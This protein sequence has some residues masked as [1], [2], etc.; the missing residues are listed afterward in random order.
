MS[1][2]AKER[3]LLTSLLPKDFVF[4]VELAGLEGLSDFSSLE[5][6]ASIPI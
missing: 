1:E 6:K 5:T 2:I 3:L 4:N